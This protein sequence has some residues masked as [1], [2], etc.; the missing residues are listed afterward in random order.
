MSSSAGLIKVTNREGIGTPLFVEPTHYKYA[1]LSFY[2]S[3]FLILSSQ[4]RFRTSQDL[5]SFITSV[6]IHEI[7]MFLVNRILVAVADVI[8]PSQNQTISLKVNL[9]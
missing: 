7:K 4:Q 6:I 8:Y 1:F 3:L 9:F 2:V 5:P